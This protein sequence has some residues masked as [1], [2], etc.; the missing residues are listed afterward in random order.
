MTRT[1]ARQYI[2]SMCWSVQVSWRYNEVAHS[3]SYLEISEAFF[4]HYDWK[5]THHWAVSTHLYKNGIKV[6]TLQAIHKYDNQAFGASRPGWGPQGPQVVS[7]RPCG[8]RLGPPGSVGAHRA[9]N[10]FQEALWRPFGA[11]RP[12]WSPQGPRWLPGGSVDVVWGLPARLGPTQP[13]MVSSRLCGDRLRP[14]GSVRANMA[15]M[16]SRRRVYIC[17]YVYMCVC[18]Y[19][20]MYEWMYVRVVSF[21]DDVEQVSL[22]PWQTNLWSPLWSSLRNSLS[23]P[24]GNS[25]WSSLW[26]PLCGP[27]WSP[28]LGL[29][30]E[31]RRY[32]CLGI[33]VCMYGCS[34]DMVACVVL[35]RWS[36]VVPWRNHCWSPV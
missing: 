34:Y 27:L 15:Q 25:L 33:Y 1:E 32:E 24:L 18:M 16:A 21:C 3:L 14:L 29:L 5:T 10:G 6:T 30:F 23:S 17:I 13:Q 36:R 20:C 8:S 19:V 9:P 22:A 7:R 26:S 31:V 12:G 2:E 28:L 11:S 4:F 35:M